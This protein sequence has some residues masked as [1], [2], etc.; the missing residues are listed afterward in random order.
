MLVEFILIRATILLK[1][2]YFQVH[3]VTEYLK[4]MKGEQNEYFNFVIFRVVRNGLGQIY[5]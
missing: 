4:K 2:R 3:F 1:I 5:S